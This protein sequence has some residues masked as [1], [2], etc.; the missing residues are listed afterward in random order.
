MVRN[1]VL[2]AIEDARNG[3]FGL[4]NRLQSPQAR[5]TRQA[6][7]RTRALLEAQWRAAT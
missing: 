7:L 4:G 6:T 1:A 5:E 3:P 2:A